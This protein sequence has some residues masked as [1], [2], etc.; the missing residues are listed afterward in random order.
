MAPFQP[1][2][3][4]CAAAASSRATRSSTAGW[5]PHDPAGLFRA[6]G[7]RMKATAR[8]D[9]FLRK[10]NGGP[11]ATHTDHAL[12]GNEPTLHVPWLYDWARQP[13][14]D[15]GGRPPRPAPLQHRAG[16]LPR[17]R[18][19]RHALLLVRLRRPRPLPRGAR[20]RPAGDR[21]PALRQATI[22]MP[23]HR[24]VTIS[25]GAH[26]VEGRGKHRRRVALSPAQAPY[27]ASLRINGRAHAKP[28][29]TYCALARGARPRLPAQPA[30]Q[31]QAG[32]AP[33][34]RR[35]PRSAP[36]SRCR[37]TPARLDPQHRPAPAPS[38]CWPS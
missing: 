32:A 5:C 21:Q 29:T 14:P 17:Q 8:L 20:S 38:G 26:T 4:T 34:P 24:R 31:P 36:A 11:G 22:A 37:S 3:T 9:H 30:S 1:I 10:L 19:P 28:W 12:L 2:T 15:P 16:R 18:R 13:V 23:H 7:G 35:R 6:I 25:A 33:P 27:I